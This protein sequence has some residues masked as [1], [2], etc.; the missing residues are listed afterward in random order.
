MQLISI[1]NRI[2]MFIDKRIVRKNFVKRHE[3]ELDVLKGEEVRV[4]GELPNSQGKWLK[5]EKSSDGKLGFVPANFL[6]AW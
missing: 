4:I 6:V 2:K 3:D 5:V 1:F